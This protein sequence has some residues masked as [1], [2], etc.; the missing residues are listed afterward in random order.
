MAT[1]HGAGVFL[2]HP[3]NELVHRVMI[4]AM[5][6]PDNKPTGFFYGPGAQVDPWV[7]P[8]GTDEAAPA[9]SAGSAA[10]PE[11]AAST[12]PE[13]AAAPEPAAVPEP[14]TAPEPAVVPEPALSAL[15]PEPAVSA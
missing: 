9:E 11:P 15:P 12:M 3:F 1:G 5:S 7:P 8:A 13:P 4:R 6:E 10:V 14:A 2:R